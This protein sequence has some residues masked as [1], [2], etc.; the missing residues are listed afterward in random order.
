MVV[1][2]GFPT[3]PSGLGRLI[4]IALADRA[5]YIRVKRELTVDLGAL[6]AHSLKQFGGWV[7]A[8]AV[9]VPVRQSNGTLLGLLP[10]FRAVPFRR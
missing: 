5:D 4:V 8:H 7:A 9:N 2:R 3:P 10:A 1:S 6:P